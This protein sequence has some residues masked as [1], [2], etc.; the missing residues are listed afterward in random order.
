MSN[1][2][3]SNLITRK[4]AC[5]PFCGCNNVQATVSTIIRCERS[6]PV[7]TDGI[8]CINNDNEVDDEPTGNTLRELLSSMFGEVTDASYYLTQ[9]NCSSC[10]KT[11]SAQMGDYKWEKGENGLYSFVKNEEIRKKGKGKKPNKADG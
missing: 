9:F 4:F 5:C 3:Q 1:E 2:K 6:Q 8:D 10:S 7:Y 11:W